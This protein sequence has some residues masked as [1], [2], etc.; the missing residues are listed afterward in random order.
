MARDGQDLSLRRTAADSLE[1][2]PAPGKRSCYRTVLDDHVMS[3]AIIQGAI[4]T[5][6]RITMGDGALRVAEV[7]SISPTLSHDSINEG[8]R[9]MVISVALVVITMLVY[10]RLAGLLAVGGLALYVLYT[11][12][13]LAGFDAVL[14]LPDIAGFVLSIVWRSTPTC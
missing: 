13:V 8:I 5:H 9:A 14:T 6:G 3:A 10:Y 7:R 11:L 4:G 1:L 12:A 2:L